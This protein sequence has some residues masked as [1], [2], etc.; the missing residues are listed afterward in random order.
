MSLSKN[1]LNSILKYIKFE[2]YFNNNYIFDITAFEPNQQI[3]FNQNIFKNKVKNKIC[4]IYSLYNP[5]AYT[6]LS[7]IFL[8]TVNIAVTSLEMIYKNLNWLEREVSEFFN[9]KYLKKT[10]T[11]NLLL[12]YNDTNNYLLKNYNTELLIDFYYNLLNDNINESK[13]QNNYI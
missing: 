8:T 2:T 11:R 4:L 10:D 5:V 3:I 13:N 12:D 6:R 9:I 1:Y 7:L